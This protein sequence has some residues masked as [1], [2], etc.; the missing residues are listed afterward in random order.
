[1]FSVNNLKRIG[2]IV[3]YAVLLIATTALTARSD[4]Y[5]YVDGNGVL[6]FTNVPTSKRYKLYMKERAYKPADRTYTDKYDHI[7]AKASKSHGVSF[8]LLKAIIKVESDFNPRAVSK[9]GAKGLMQLMP[10][11]ISSFNLKDPFDP[12]EN[13]MGGAKYIREL[14]DRFGGE[15]QLSL[16][17]YNAGP[18][19]VDRYQRIPPFKETEAYIQKVMAHYYELRKG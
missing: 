8:Q 5:M 10:E 19:S 17:A 4:I 13:I 2:H 14:L 12:V 3:L 7:I 1:M 15:L 11:N 6:H 18:S 16:A 9:K